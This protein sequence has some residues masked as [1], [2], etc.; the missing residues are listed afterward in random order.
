MKNVRIGPI[1]RASRKNGKQRV[2]YYVRMRWQDASGKQQ[3][4]EY[5][6]KSKAEQRLRIAELEREYG[7]VDSRAL[8]ALTLTVEEAYAAYAKVRLIP[9]QYAEGKRI[10]GR[11]SLTGPRATRDAVIAYLGTRLLREL[12][13]AD[14][15]AYR[16]HR[17]NGITIRKGPRRIATVN[18]ELSHFRVMLNWCIRQGWIDRNPFNAGDQLIMHKLESPR[19]RIITPEEEAKLLAQCVGRRAHVAPIII[20]AL[21]TGMR[22]IE[23][24]NLRWQDVDLTEGL[25]IVRLDKGN[26]SR[27]VAMTKRLRAELERLW[28]QS[29]RQPETRVFGFSYC[30]RT[31]FEGVVDA[32]GLDVNFHDLKR[33]AIT[34][35]I[36]SGIPPEF[37]GKTTGNV[38]MNIMRRHYIHQTLKIVRDNAAALDRYNQSIGEQ[39][40]ELSPDAEKQAS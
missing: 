26:R 5:K 8:N 2:E 25:L 27:T 21:D 1:Q 32:A 13:H 28:Q 9:V 11:A 17:L 14:I 7:Q 16:L 15:D 6:V 34:R 29:D 30:C 10:A 20:C 3:A 19:T 38:T 23:I 36:E 35:M 31:A 24:K 33:T 12:T 22:H 39:S 37:V 40:G 4:K 18:S